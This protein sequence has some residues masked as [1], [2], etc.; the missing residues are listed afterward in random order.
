MRNTRFSGGRAATSGSAPWMPMVTSRVPGFHGVG[1]TLT[2]DEK[3]SSV[4]GAW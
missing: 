2:V 4:V 3:A 1:M